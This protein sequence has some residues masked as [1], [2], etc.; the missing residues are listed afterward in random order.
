[1]LPP[2]AESGGIY[3]EVSEDYARLAELSLTDSPDAAKDLMGKA[4]EYFNLVEGPLQPSERA[5]KL[6]ELIHSI[7]DKVLPEAEPSPPPLPPTPPSPPEDQTAAWL[8]SARGTYDRAM[9]AEAA[10]PEAAQKQY[11]VVIALCERVLALHPA[12]APAKA[13]FD[14]SK[15]A[16]L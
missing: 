1:P 4:E 16:I 14:N 7:H 12:N 11:Q 6:K 9:A 8:N 10:S 3:L 13:L 5:Q 2:S 15:K